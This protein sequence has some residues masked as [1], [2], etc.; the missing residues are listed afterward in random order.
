MPDQDQIDAVMVRALQDDALRTHPLVA[1]IVTQE[2]AT[3]AGAFMARLVTGAATP[4][5]LLAHT[6]AGLRTQLPSA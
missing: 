3:E 5:V 2:E 4:Y 1:W 6:L